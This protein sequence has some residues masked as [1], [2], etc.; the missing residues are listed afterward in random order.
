MRFLRWTGIGLAVL[1]VARV[2]LAIATRFSEGPLG[3]HPLA[4][5]P[6]GPLRAADGIEDER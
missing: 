4:V 6:G 5:F 2:G 3:D 1:V